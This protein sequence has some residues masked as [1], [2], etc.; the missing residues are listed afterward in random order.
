M[1]WIDLECAE[2]FVTLVRR[3]H[4][5]RAAVELHIS[6]SALSKRL[7]RLERQVR[8]VLIIRGPSGYVGLTPAGQRFLAR[9]HHLLAEARSPTDK[10]PA[11]VRLGVPGRAGDILPPMAVRLVGGCLAQS[12]GARLVV[13]G[14]PFGADDEWLLRDLVDVMLTVVEPRRA[15]LLE[16]PLAPSTRVVSLAHTNPLAEARLLRI[17]DLADLRIV[18]VPEAEQHWISPW[19]LA[20][21]DSAR[22]RAGVENVNARGVTE[23]AP[24]IVQDRACGV[25]ID[26]LA[27]RLEQFSTVLPLVDAPALLTRATCRVGED[28]SAVITLLDILGVFARAALPVDSSR[29]VC[30]RPATRSST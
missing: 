8:E 17:D 13:C 28:R 21:V 12:S 27:E 14:V 15:G 9:A 5:A 25:F 20:D 22:P 24:A 3:E 11:V 7:T 16:T 2:S 1:E 6:T 10:S 30:A 18:A 29:C 19:C 23:L 26:L 4:F